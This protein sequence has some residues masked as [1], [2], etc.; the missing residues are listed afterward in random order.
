MGNLSIGKTEAYKMV[1]AK[2]GNHML[3]V[4]E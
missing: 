2:G 4:T 3:G 1:I